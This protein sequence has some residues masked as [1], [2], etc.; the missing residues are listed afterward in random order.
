M[1]TDRAM[2]VQSSFDASQFRPGFDIV[3]PMLLGK[4]A[5]YDWKETPPL[6]PAKRKY[7]LSFQGVLSPYRSKQSGH[8]HVGEENV[9]MISTCLI[10]HSVLNKIG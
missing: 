5:S 3:A 1:N 7:L 2:V 8:G 6:I 4:E 9:V 10:R